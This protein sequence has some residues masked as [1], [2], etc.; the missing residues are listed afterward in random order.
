MCHFFLKFQKTANLYF[1]IMDIKYEIKKEEF[2]CYIGSITIELGNLCV[3]FCNADKG[4]KVCTLLKR[5]SPRSIICK[6]KKI[7]HKPVLIKGEI[8]ASESVIQ[9]KV[10]EKKIKWGN[11][12]ELAGLLREMEEKTIHIINKID[13]FFEREVYHRIS[14]A[15][16]YNWTDINNSKHKVMDIGDIEMD[17]EYNPL[18]YKQYSFYTDTSFIR[19]NDNENI[20]NY[21]KESFV[22]IYDETIRE[23]IE[24]QKKEKKKQ[25]ERLQKLLEE[26]ENSIITANSYANSM[27]YDD[28]ASMMY[29]IKNGYGDMIGY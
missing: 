8:T 26:R 4:E 7:L 28:E 10:S 18:L 11:Q 14:R 25:G 27:S 17:E 22:D 12:T 16:I 19:G 2:N 24:E 13:V 21:I 29:A 1:E 20:N 15:D 5:P 3:I 9:Q 6:K 23:I